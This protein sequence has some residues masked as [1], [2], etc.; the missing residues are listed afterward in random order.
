MTLLVR[1]LLLVGLALLPALVIQVYQQVELRSASARLTEGNALRTLALVEGGLDRT[2]EGVRQ[3]LMI[4]SETVVVRR[5]D[6]P[7]CRALLARVSASLITT[8]VIHVT[9]RDGMVWCSNDAALVGTGLGDRPYVQEAM[10]TDGFV[11]GDYISRRANQHPALPFAVAY[12]TFDGAIGGTVIAILET[13]ALAKVLTVGALPHGSLVTLAD[14]NGRIL[15]CDPPLRPPGQMIENQRAAVLDALDRGTIE[16]HDADGIDRLVAYSP[17]VTGAPRLFLSVGL[18]RRAMLAGT[19]ATAL[20]GLGLVALD[21]VVALMLAIFAYRR[22]IHRP[23]NSIH[24][25]ALRWR[26]GDYSARPVQPSCRE[27]NDLFLT[28]TK[29]AEAVAGRE[30]DHR[31]RLEAERAANQAREMLAVAMEAA[32][33]GWWAWDVEQDIVTMSE[34]GARLLGVNSPASGHT[35]EDWLATVHPEDRDSVR[36]RVYDELT[37]QQKMFR[38]EFRVHGPPDAERWLASIGKTAFDGHG[39]AVGTVGIVLDITQQKQSEAELVAARRQAEEANRHKTSFLASAS[40]DLR[41]PVQSLM[42]FS[43]ALAGRTH[44]PKEQAII[45]RIDGAIKSLKA[46]LDGLL[47]ISRLEAGN[48][49]PQIADLPLQPLFTQIATEYG[50]QARQR[51]LQLKVVPTAMWVRTDGALLDRV[52]RNLI[53]NA[54]KYTRQGGILL[55]C[56]RHGDCVSIEVLDTGIGIPNAAM[57]L[58]FE[59]FHQ[60]DNPERDTAKGLGLGLAIV[61]RLSQ[62]VGYRVTVDSQLGRG[63]RFAVAVLRAPA[64]GH[65][66]PEAVS[67]EHRDSLPGYVVLIEDEEAVREGLEHQLADWGVD[68]LAGPDDRAVAMQLGG[69]RPDLI[70]ADY[71]LKGGV[72]GVQAIRRLADIVG[73]AVPSVLLTGETDPRQLDEIRASGLTILHKPLQPSD[74]RRELSRMARQG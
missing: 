34:H 53:E 24:A 14:R 29:M 23:L 28:F 1:I 7:G 47:D 38:L 55:G 56:R 9:G 51:G 8:E 11:I 71:R 58:I 67:H 20:T 41:Q 72:T 63:T 35:V 70:I 39:R 64:A 18:D 2:V 52:L 60:I 49:S 19:N 42:L 54:I 59:E 26:D 65:A 48:V 45:S 46:L 33:A 21:L 5:R 6:E 73:T 43:S 4:L 69:R 22:L 68:V 15:L 44:D 13:A 61:R 57:K 25:A 40:H 62:L 30:E 66:P 32:G 50:M 37:K 36:V 31:A 3:T 27:F 12:H 74:L 10:A 16:V 17:L